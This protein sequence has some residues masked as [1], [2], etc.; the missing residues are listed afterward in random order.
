MNIVKTPHYTNN[1]DKYVNITSINALIVDKH[2][3]L[4][5]FK[6]GN[7]ETLCLKDGK[8][9]LF[10]I[11]NYHPLKEFYLE[12]EEILVCLNSS[13]VETFTDSKIRVGHAEYKLS[14]RINWDGFLDTPPF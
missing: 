7:K 5:I 11:Y 14:N 8:E 1:Q 9:L 4:I 12:E 13:I 6:S 10:N 3:I 2:K